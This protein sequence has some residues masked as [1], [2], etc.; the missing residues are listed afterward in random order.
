MDELPAAAAIVIVGGGFAGAATA[1][2]L[3]RAGITDVVVLEREPIC[4]A[5]ASGKNAA[6]CRQ[7]ADDDD[8]TVLTV[9][10][11]AFLREPPPGFSDVPL[12]S[13]TGGFLVT[14]TAAASDVLLARARA[15]RSARDHVWLHGG[16]AVAAA[17]RHARADRD[18]LRRRRRDRC[19]CGADR[20]PRRCAA[21]GRPRGDPL[22]AAD[23][24]GSRGRAQH[25]D[26]ARRDPCDDDRVRGR[27]V[28]RRGRRSRGRR[29]R[30]RAGEAPPVRRGARPGRARSAVRLAPRRRAVLRAARGR[31]RA[32]IALRRP[33]RRAGRGAAG[34]R[35]RRSPGRAHPGRGAGSGRRAGQAHVGVP[36]DVHARA[37]HAHR[38]G[39]RAP[40]AV[41]GRGPDGPRRDREPGGRR[42]RGVRARAR[43][44]PGS[45]IRGGLATV[46]Q[47]GARGDAPPS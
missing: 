27:G 34:S 20:L 35:R 11:A 30:V 38:L 45:V 43:S 3:A 8:T 6:I 1:W 32:A 41:L 13:R 36:A 24:R 22:R 10:G 25:R 18:L 46:T 12:M 42:A 15:P 7:I 23:D 37:P 4:G 47:S 9:R 26:L 31:G 44:R 5:H 14:D 21:R 39:R 33:D 2:W 29:V 40:V 17:R 19:R 28:G 16:A